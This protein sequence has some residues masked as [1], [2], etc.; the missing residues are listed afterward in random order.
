MFGF[1]FD[2][3][4]TIGMTRNDWILFGKHENYR[5]IRNCRDTRRIRGISRASA[6]R[7]SDTRSRHDSSFSPSPIS[8]SSFFLLLRFPLS[9]FPLCFSRGVGR[10]SRVFHLQLPPEMAGNG[11]FFSRSLRRYGYNYVPLE[12]SHFLATYRRRPVT[13]EDHLGKHL[14]LP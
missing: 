6:M 9:D 13:R 5:S 4:T 10:L 11:S 12:T 1:E 2:G 14:L 7:N 3:Y 8:S